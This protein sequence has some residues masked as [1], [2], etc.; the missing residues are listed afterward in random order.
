MLCH[1]TGDITSCDTVAHYSQI[2]FILYKKEIE[3]R[4][5]KL[6]D[7]I[8]R[9][10]EENDLYVKLEKEKESSNKIKGSKY[11]IIDIF[12]VNM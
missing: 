6:V 12:Y 3:K 9:R 4:N 7:E 11:T 5:D 1:L 2:I 8:L 10:M